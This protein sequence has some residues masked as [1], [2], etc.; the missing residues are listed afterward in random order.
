[1]KFENFRT[2]N[3]KFEISLHKYLYQQKTFHARTLLKILS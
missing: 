2:S 1:M 3:F